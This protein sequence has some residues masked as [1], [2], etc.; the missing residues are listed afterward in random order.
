MGSYI[1]NF[2][3]PISTQRLNFIPKMQCH[4]GYHLEEAQEN[5]L[6]AF[7]EAKKR[8]S[9]MIELDVRQSLDN[10][11]VVFHDENLIR[12]GFN[13]RADQLTATELHEKIKAP[14]L[15]EVL[16]DSG[17]PHWINIELKAEGTKKIGFEE[18]VVDIVLANKAQE[19]VLFSSFNPLVLR[20]LYYLIPEIPR[21]LIVSEKREPKNKFYLRKALFASWSCAHLVHLE[22]DMLTPSLAFILRK[23]EIPFAVWTVN[24]PI[25]FDYFYKLGALSI[26]SD[27]AL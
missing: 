14:T 17:V 13:E 27:L 18:R 4:R 3:Q 7:R 5:T 9:Q 22:K 19:R 10:E 6:E 2:W 21:A 12:F 20:R 15:N 25:Q 16:Q 8:G 1:F 26:I 11:I 23:R 24:D